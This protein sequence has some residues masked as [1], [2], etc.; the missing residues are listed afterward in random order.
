MTSRG[1]NDSGEHQ[2]EEVM[3]IGTGAYGTVYKGR[4]LNNE[5]RFVAMKM[6]RLQNNAEEGM[7]MS[8]WIS[9]G[10]GEIQLRLVFEFMDQDLSTFLEKCPPPGL[11]PEKIKDLMYQMLRGVDFL[12]ANRIIHRD[13][14]P[15]NVLI[16][17]DGQ[18]K[19]ADFGLARVYAFQMALTQV[20]TLWYRAPEVILQAQYATPVDIWSCGCIFAELYNRKPL[21]VGQSDI[22][23][24][25]K[26]FELRGR[27][28]ES[29]WLSSV[30]L[31]WSSFQAFPPKPVSSYLPEMEHVAIDL[32]EKLLA[33]NPHHR[34]SAN[35]A[36]NHPYF[37]DMDLESVRTTASLSPVSTSEGDSADSR[38][39]T[40]V[41][42]L[43][44]A[45]FF[46][47]FFFFPPSES[48]SEDELLEE[49]E[50]EEELP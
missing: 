45:G 14:K 32:F 5:G 28:L 46:A 30:T 19:L 39:D 35:E 22:D 20:V 2:Y 11:G 13:L 40:P 50:E 17:A 18:L 15:Q 37:K 29:E 25:I 47:A 31:P 1:R 34:I 43:A 12:H 49:E 41:K 9:S 21:F 24:L 48:E 36:L 42:D 4:D 33:F 26:I 6:I 44:L 23:Q 38:S 27:P 10:A 8:C 3:L 16:S 7:P